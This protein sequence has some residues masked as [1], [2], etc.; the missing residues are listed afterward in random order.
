MHQLPEEGVQANIDLNSK[1]MV[2]IHWGMFD[3]S[4]HSWY[5]PIERVTKAARQKGVTIVAPKLGQLISTKREFVQEEWWRPIIN[6][7][8]S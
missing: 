6:W 5:E 4:V 3:L 7:V 1:A 8:K 2:P